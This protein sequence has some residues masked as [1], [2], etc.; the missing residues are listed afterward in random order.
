MPLTTPPE[1]KT[2]NTCNATKTTDNFIDRRGAFGVIRVTLQC[3][4]CRVKRASRTARRLEASQRDA[5]NSDGT[6]PSSSVP[7]TPTVERTKRA[8]DNVQSPQAARGPPHAE[9]AAVRPTSS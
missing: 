2:C 8:I 3:D 1:T 4:A 9:P 5:C 6:S 7:R